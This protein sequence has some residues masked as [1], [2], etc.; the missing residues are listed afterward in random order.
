MVKTHLGVPAGISDEELE[1]GTLTTRM[2]R[3]LVRYLCAVRRAVTRRERRQRDPALQGAEE[4][5]TTSGS[6][7]SSASVSGSVSGD[8][9]GPAARRLAAH[10]TRCVARGVG[11][12]MAT[13]GR[14]AI[15]YVYVRTIA[16]ADLRV[17]VFGPAGSH[18]CS[19]NPPALADHQ[20]ASD[21]FILVVFLVS[22]NKVEVRYTPRLA[23]PHHVHV[24]LGGSAVVGSPFHVLVAEQD[25]PPPA[26]VEEGER[27]ED[28]PGGL[29]AASSPRR[30]HRSPRRRRVK[31]VYRIVDFV[32]EKMLLTEDGRLERLPDAIVTHS[33]TP[34][35]VYVH[36]HA[37]AVAGGAATPKGR[38]SKRVLPR[39]Q[40]PA[41]AA[42]RHRARPP[43]TASEDSSSEQDEEDSKPPQP[44]QA[45]G[46]SESRCLRILRT[47]ALILQHFP[48]TRSLHIMRTA[49]DIVS[50]GAHLRRPP[51]LKIVHPEDDDDDLDGLTEAADLAPSVA[52]TDA[53]MDDDSGTHVEAL[54][55]CYL[56]S[57]R[58]GS[59][60]SVEE[61]VVTATRTL[62]FGL[63]PEVTRLLND[64][65]LHPHDEA[66]AQPGDAQYGDEQAAE[67]QAAD[68]EV[69]DIT[70]V[71]DGDM[72]DCEGP[73]IP[74]PPD[75]TS[76][77]QEEATVTPADCERLD[78]TPRSSENSVS[79]L[80]PGSAT[81]SLSNSRPPEVEM[82]EHV[83]TMSKPDAAPE[84]GTSTTKIASDTL[85][86][87]VKEHTE[88]QA[89][90][91]NITISHAGC[92][93]E[94]GVA[95]PK[96]ESQAE[97]LDEGSVHVLSVGT[98]YVPPVNTA[99][100]EPPLGNVKAGNVGDTRAGGEVA[101][102]APESAEVSTKAKENPL[103]SPQSSPRARPMPD[104]TVP[105]AQDPDAQG[106]ET[107]ADDQFK[108]WP[109]NTAFGEPELG[110][111]VDFEPVIAAPSLDE[112][113]RQLDMSIQKARNGHPPGSQA[114][115]L[116][117]LDGLTFRLQDSGAGADIWAEGAAADIEDLM[118]LMAPQ[119]E[120]RPPPRPES[121]RPPLCSW[122]SIIREEGEEDAGQRD[123]AVMKDTIAQE[124]SGES[125]K[126]DG[127]ESVERTLQGTIIMSP[128][129]PVE[130][131]GQLLRRESG[132]MAVQSVGSE[133]VSVE[134]VGQDA[135]E[136][137]VEGE[138]VEVQSVI[139]DTT[140]KE[141]VAQD[142][143]QIECGEARS[144]Q[145]VI[146]GTA[147]VEFAT[148]VAGQV[149]GRDEGVI[150]QPF[151]SDTASVEIVGQSAEQN[152][153]ENEKLAG[154]LVIS[155]TTSVEVVGQ[156][157]EEI[158]TEG[159]GVSEQS[160]ISVTTPMEAVGQG[161]E[162]AE[163]DGEGVRVQS[164]ISDTTPVEV[165][166]QAD[167]EIRREGEGV[168]EQSIISVTTPVDVVGQGAEEI[169]REG[170]GVTEQRIISVVGQ[171]AEQ[172]E[173][174]GEG[175]RVQSVISDTTSVEVAVQD[176]KQIGGEG[177]EGSEVLDIS[178]NT[179]AKVTGQ[180]AEQAGEKSGYLSEQRVISDTTSMEVTNSCAEAPAEEAEQRVSEQSKE[181]VGAD[182]T[183][184]EVTDQAAERPKKPADVQPEQS[185]SVDRSDQSAE[186]TAQ[187]NAAGSATEDQVAATDNEEIEKHQL[188]ALVETRV[189]NNVRGEEKDMEDT[190]PRG[191]ATTEESDMM[192]NNTELTEK[193]VQRAQVVNEKGSCEGVDQSADVEAHS[194]NETLQQGTPDLNIQDEDVV[195]P[196]V[197]I[198]LKEPTEN[199]FASEKT[200]G[201]DVE[202][203]EGTACLKETTSPQIG[204]VQENI[205]PIGV[206]S[207]QIEHT[208]PT[209]PK[210][211]N[212]PEADPSGVRGPEENY[213]SPNVELEEEPVQSE[214]AEERAELQEASPLLEATAQ[215][216]EPGENDTPSTSKATSVK[217][218]P[219]SAS[220]EIAT[221]HLTGS[222]PKSQ[223]IVLGFTDEQVKAAKDEISTGVV[224]SLPS[225]QRPP[226]VQDVA[227]EV[228]K[229]AE[230]VVVSY[231]QEES[232]VS[233]APA[234]SIAEPQETR[235]A[236]CPV[237]QPRRR[238]KV[239]DMVAAIEASS[240]EKEGPQVESHP[241]PSRLTTRQVEPLPHPETRKPDP[242]VE[243][244]TQTTDSVESHA[245]NK[246][247]VSVKLAQGCQGAPLSQSHAES[248]SESHNEPLDESL[249]ESHSKPATESH[250]EPLIEFNEEPIT[251]PHDESLPESNAGYHTEPPAESNEEPI[252]KSYDESLPEPNAEYHTEPLAE[253]NEE[254]IS[255]S[256][257]ESLPESNAE[258]HTE[259]LAESNEE[260]IT[261]PLAESPAEP[262]AE[263][264]ALPL[265]LP[266][267]T[268]LVMNIE[269]QRAANNAAKTSGGDIG[270]EQRDGKSLSESQ[271]IES[272]RENGSTVAVDNV[273]AE[274]NPEPAE[275]ASAE[276]SAALLLDSLPLLSPDSEKEIERQFES[277]MKTQCQPV[278]PVE[279]E[280]NS[281][282]RE[283]TISKQPHARSYPATKFFKYLE[284]SQD[285]VDEPSFLGNCD[286]VD[287][288]KALT[289][290]L[291]SLVEDLAKPPIQENTP[292]VVA[293]AAV[294]AGRTE[295]E[296]EGSPD[297]NSVA[298]FGA[299]GALQVRLGEGVSE[300]AVGH[301]ADIA[302][303]LENTIEGIEVGQ[304]GQ[305]GKAQNRERR[306]EE[307]ES[308]LELC[309]KL[310][311]IAGQ[312]QHHLSPATT[313]LPGPCDS[314]YTAVPT[315]E[316]D[317]DI[318]IVT[319]SG[320]D[321]TIRMIATP[322]LSPRPGPTTTSADSGSSTYRPPVPPKPPV[323][324]PRR[325][326]LSPSSPSIAGP[327]PGPE[328]EPGPGP[329]PEPRPSPTS[330][331]DAEPVDRKH[332]LYRSLED[333]SETKQLSLS[334]PA[335]SDL[336]DLDSLISEA[337]FPLSMRVTHRKLFWDKQL[338]RNTEGEGVAH[339]PHAA[340][341]KG[342]GI[343]SDR[344]APAPAASS[345]VH[346]VVLTS[347]PPRQAEPER[348]GPPTPPPKPTPRKHRVALAPS[349]PEDFTAGS[350]SRLQVLRKART[351]TGACEAEA[352]PAAGIVKSGRR[353]FESTAQQQKVSARTPCCAAE[354]VDPVTRIRREIEALERRTQQVHQAQKRQQSAFNVPKK[355]APP[356]PPPV[357]TSTTATAFS[358]SV[359]ASGT[360]APGGGPGSRHIDTGSTAMRTSKTSNRALPTVELE[361]DIGA[362]DC[363][364]GASSTLLERRERFE[365][366]KTYFKK[367]E[368]PKDVLGEG[369][370][371]ISLKGT[372]HRKAVLAALSSMDSPGE[373]TSPYDSVA[374]GDGT[375]LRKS[376]E[377]LDADEDGGPPNNN[378][379]NFLEHWYKFLIPCILNTKWPTNSAIGPKVIH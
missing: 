375:L 259:P 4:S 21:T 239:R 144:V 119:P 109:S 271:E 314:L 360:S 334:A 260:P 82:I 98:N 244:Q 81:E 111:V 167:D 373:A 358:A 327:G 88:V 16:V 342:R 136:T 36:Y 230:E 94:A 293:E 15:F 215:E 103:S 122:M 194:A 349:P 57:S 201:I 351:R 25:T 123:V 274:T 332:P 198:G 43:P 292:V 268:A 328:P 3:R 282:V 70:G 19:G 238:S 266:R 127:E 34:P 329:E 251:K 233:E 304:L 264:P 197:N 97:S 176:P 297:E 371:T 338:Q 285:S 84:Q 65:A 206:I 223:K 317:D 13:R 143:K 174:D 257:D 225:E 102:I 79:A 378:D 296:D 299:M 107:E 306:K 153:R 199:H 147:S 308:L 289:E 301:L 128:A 229:T 6:T 96:V 120:V 221:V 38:V 179:S 305:Q 30:P 134:V 189:E 376:F 320:S 372:P 231:N 11:L 237:V 369:R 67:E 31:V 124:V 27:D 68:K 263:H 370:T 220:P 312:G 210:E 33:T 254:P 311:L 73:D 162:Q 29:K 318:L 267:S 374:D 273:T 283:P 310:L 205:D 150:V 72:S 42:A 323:R 64:A 321:T 203:L 207:L 126:Q 56:D 319:Q 192:S 345:A 130:V 242:R 286:Q 359:R 324:S 125:D 341:A 80:S 51:P 331:G 213:S 178:P 87:V 46:T 12:F 5:S 139:P 173:G 316:P 291:Q 363:A 280:F 294:A 129:V 313:G 182:T 140:P 121:P 307:E 288:S 303:A 187:Q 66:V 243:L 300:D 61:V 357:A 222:S 20:A 8:Q 71:I 161:A 191:E 325:K 188:T 74:W 240:G 39:G 253:S 45:N 183:S 262:F 279:A 362:I 52:D 202:N 235:E 172:A 154:Q 241:R 232:K 365:R 216:G 336:G 170:E 344:P 340:P 100:V 228:T 270:P 366:A 234:D 159:E 108:S 261:K 117:E 160:I 93:S 53:S 152:G 163:G 115:V 322:P 218:T 277:L 249:P 17:E 256:Y 204:S 171:G 356:P 37:T 113:L 77:M 354:V 62:V 92:N 14:P 269:K 85:E 352:L 193:S 295:K 302:D 60:L 346:T 364:V 337:G 69:A 1:A 330:Q 91:M 95:G 156:S 226:H 112:A 355:R 315:I 184:L 149:G 276:D 287:G 196:E 181:A 214:P 155:D 275:Q 86:N 114:D 90:S 26:A 24:S 157:A 35:R 146:S 190:V 165:A 151:I 284:E 326:H 89:T 245:G 368:D 255:K 195:A 227:L 224:A 106:V 49:D 23:G 272:I 335:E 347:T 76:R 219:I 83:P 101:L 40:R 131:V 18:G 145:S 138:E 116:C 78:K 180:T 32:T 186:A 158:R 177:E 141:V 54:S 63:V 9:V 148:Q 137:G 333:V 55:A 367:L 236:P 211:Q 104:V 217:S 142:S 353:F 105:T 247:S 265:P 343:T 28:V 200:T 208:E 250:A 298:E 164:V 99:S 168:T 41:V 246:S 278:E 48:K 44:A 248:C 339:A 175:V 281:L 50:G 379:H 290:A 309:D 212:V 2:E 258:Y 169:R 22:I 348:Q 185:I 75:T 135:E 133:T 59:S 47:C 350:S 7:D 377:D 361:Q 10:A 166:G 58:P 110:S 252:S 118:G 132:E 209:A